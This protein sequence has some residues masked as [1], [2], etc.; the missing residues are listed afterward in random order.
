[1]PSSARPTGMITG[2]LEIQSLVLIA[3]TDWTAILMFLPVTFGNVSGTTM[4]PSLVFWSVMGGMSMPAASLPSASM[5]M[6]VGT[7]C[8]PSL[9][10]RRSMWS[11]EIGLASW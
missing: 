4:V 1:M 6:R 10:R 9:T 8:R 2:S 11:N 7:E 3:R 5:K